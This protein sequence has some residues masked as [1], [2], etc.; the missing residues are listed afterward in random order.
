MFGEESEPRGGNCRMKGSTRKLTLRLPASQI[1][2]DFQ[3]VATALWSWCVK[4]AR[5]WMQ[6][7]LCHNSVDVRTLCPSERVLKERVHLVLMLS[8]QNQ[9]DHEPPQWQK[10]APLYL[11]KGIAL[12]A[13]TQYVALPGIGKRRRRMKQAAG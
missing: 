6:K 8:L 12:T 4:A 1:Q 9:T 2:C 13:L 10:V 7:Q 3:G 11:F 5:V